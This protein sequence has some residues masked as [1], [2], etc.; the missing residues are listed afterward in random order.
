MSEAEEDIKPT[1]ESKQGLLRRI[2]VVAF[3]QYLAAFGLAVGVANS[4]ALLSALGSCYWGLISCFLAAEVMMVLV[5]FLDFHRFRGVLGYVFIVLFT[6][7]F[8]AVFGAFLP[9]VIPSLVLGLGMLLAMS[10]GALLYILAFYPQET[11]GDKTIPGEFKAHVAVPGG[12]LL[13]LLLYGL[14]ASIYHTEATMQLMMW[15]FIEGGFIIYFSLI[16]EDI[17]HDPNLCQED[18]CVGAIKIYSESL[19]ILVSAFQTKSVAKGK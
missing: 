8:V 17:H 15:T 19:I 6:L 1:P 3:V 13:S 5:H 2:V 14:L 10:L 16:L 11:V 12:L 18:W 7:L 9:A 4:P